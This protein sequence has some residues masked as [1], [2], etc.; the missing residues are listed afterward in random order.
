ML[1]V[2]SQNTDTL[3]ASTAMAGVDMRLSPHAY[4][5]LHWHK[6]N[7]WAYMLKV[8]QFEESRKTH[9]T[10]VSRDPFALQLSMSWDNP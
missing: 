9:L 8:S 3:P 7:E 4:R 10:F 1:I 6:A 5:E 2:L